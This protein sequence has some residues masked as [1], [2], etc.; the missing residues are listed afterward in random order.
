MLLNAK[1]CINWNCVFKSCLNPA[2]HY[3]ASIL[4]SNI[5]IFLSLTLLPASLLLPVPQRPHTVVVIIPLFDVYGSKVC[6][7]LINIIV[8]TLFKTI[9]LL[10]S[11][12]LFFFKLGFGL[13]IG[14]LFWIW[15]VSLAGRTQTNFL[16][17]LR[18][19]K[20]IILI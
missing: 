19:L 20:Q 6:S 9:I 8:G 1:Y 18:W 11:L 14:S 16:S 15:I 2:N 12:C 13:M 10:F 17:K 4:N 7:D 3:L 5:N